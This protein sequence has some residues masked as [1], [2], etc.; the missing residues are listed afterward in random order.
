MLKHRGQSNRR[1][2]ETVMVN[3][4]AKQRRSLSKQNGAAVQWCNGAMVQNH[5]NNALSVKG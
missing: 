4:K 5:E 1:S 3:K 2:A